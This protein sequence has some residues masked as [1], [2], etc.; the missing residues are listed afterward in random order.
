MIE[1]TREKSGWVSFWQVPGFS[2]DGGIVVREG[3]EQTDH[4]R[5]EQQR[6]V[7]VAGPGVPAHPFERRKYRPLAKG[8]EGGKRCTPHLLELHIQADQHAVHAA[9]G[10]VGVLT[11][12]HAQDV[13][14]ALNG[15]RAGTGEGV[16]IA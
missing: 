10:D 9:P 13:H 15:A 5:S 1:C 7:V 3:V 2:D 12:H 8:G 4:R 14:H 6:A 16:R 11:V